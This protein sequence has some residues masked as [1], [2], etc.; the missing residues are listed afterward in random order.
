V[1]ASGAVG[2]ASLAADGWHEFLWRQPSSRSGF[3]RIR[4]SS[5]AKG[6]VGWTDSLGNPLCD[7]L[8]YPNDDAKARSNLWFYSNP[9]FLERR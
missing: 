5:R 2:A 7:E 6:V 8:Q 9:V 4:G 3:F 1:V